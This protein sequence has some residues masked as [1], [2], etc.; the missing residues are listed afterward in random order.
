NT[1]DE[2]LIVNRKN[3]MPT[4][5]RAQ[6]EDMVTGQIVFFDEVNYD[7]AKFLISFSSVP[8]NLPLTPT[9]KYKITLSSVQLKLYDF[10]LY[11]ESALP[12]ID[13]KNSYKISSTYIHLITGGSYTRLHL[14]LVVGFTN[15][16]ISVPETPK[17]TPFALYP[18]PANAHIIVAAATDEKLQLRIY[19]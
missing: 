15:D 16:V 12:F 7:P 8:L 2:I 13:S 14:P 11:E 3:T 5:F 6:I 17:E 9:S 1:I 19:S 10:Q 4:S 18:N